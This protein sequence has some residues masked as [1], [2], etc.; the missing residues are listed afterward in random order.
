MTIDG[1]TA[2]DFDDAISLRILENGNFDLGVHIADVSHYVKQGG[3]LDDEARLRGTSVV[4]FQSV[5]SRCFPNGFRMRILFAE[6]EGR[7][8]HDVI[9]DGSRCTGSSSEI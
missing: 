8:A 1:E 2:R 9:I 5:P 6:S 3:A 4:S 7:P